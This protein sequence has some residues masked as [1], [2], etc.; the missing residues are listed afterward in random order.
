M[1]SPNLPSNLFLTSVNR[2]MERMCEEQPDVV[3]V[4]SSILST[5]SVIRK[6]PMHKLKSDIIFVDVLSVKQFPR[7]LFLEVTFFFLLLIFFWVKF[8]ISFLSFIGLNLWIPMNFRFFH[9]NLALCAHT[10]CSAQR[11]EKMAGPVCRLFMIKS[12]SL[13]MALKIGNVLS[14]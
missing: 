3:L 1:Y 7:N 8:V 10:Q 9:L 13:I 12:E 4:C 14:F 5:E 2:D 6:I 11:V